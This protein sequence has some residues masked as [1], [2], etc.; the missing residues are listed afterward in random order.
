MLLLQFVQ[1]IITFFNLL[2][3]YIYIYVHTYTYL[4]IFNKQF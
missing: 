4:Y 3:I 1:V 2:Y